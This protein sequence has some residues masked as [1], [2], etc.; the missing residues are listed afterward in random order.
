MTDIITVTGLVATVPFVVNQ[1]DK[2][3]F[4]SFRLASNQRYF[5][6]RS[7][8]WVAGDTNWYTVT[9]F[10]AL[11]VNA[12]ASVHKGD[13][14]LVTGRL[15]VRRWESGEKSGLAVDVEADSLG[16]D[17]VWGTARYERTTQRDASAPPEPSIT[18][19]TARSTDAAQRAGD[20]DAPLSGPEA[21]DVA[22]PGR[23][24]DD[25]VSASADPVDTPF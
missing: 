11:A 4:T 14:V 12:A 7:S 8:Q 17:L 1:P 6:R 23:Q 2:V 10:R 25:L 19:E 21:W 15:K 5:D 22:T 20:V 13:R 24:V 18:D 9:A 3:P 16:H